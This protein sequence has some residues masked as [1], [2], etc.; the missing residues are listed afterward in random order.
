MRV[1]V[2]VLRGQDVLWGFF[3]ASTTWEVMRIAFSRGERGAAAAPGRAAGFEERQHAFETGEFKYRSQ[4]LSLF[5]PEGSTD[6][7]T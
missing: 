6:H 4:L 1:L 7:R 2:V 3:K 5:D